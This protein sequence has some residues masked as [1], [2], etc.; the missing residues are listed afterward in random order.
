MMSTPKPQP[1]NP[2]SEAM[3]LLREA[4]RHI[5]TSE[6]LIGQ[7]RRNLTDN[8]VIEGLLIL[9]LEHTAKSKTAV[10]RAAKLLGV[11]P[12]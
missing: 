12:A 1:A 8:V 11:R 2:Y 3:T 5:Q 6:R 4:W 7:A 9:A 10:E